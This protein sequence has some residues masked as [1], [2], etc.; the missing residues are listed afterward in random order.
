MPFINEDILAQ[1]PWQALERAVARL[2]LHGNFEEVKLVGQ[3]GD[4]GADVLAKR[5]GKRYLVQVKF[6]KH[7]NTSNDVVDEVLQSTRDYNAEVSIIATNRYFTKDVRK[8]Q[9][10][11]L[12]E[13]V[14][15][16]LW[17]YHKLKREWD[18]LEEFSKKMKSPREYQ[19]SPIKSI[20]TSYSSLAHNSGLVVMAT[21][22]GKTF[23]V[24]SAIGQLLSENKLRKV[25]VLAHTNELVYQLERSF[26]PYIS[27]N[28][29][30]NIY[31]GVEKGD[32]QN[33][34]I[35]FA[36][37]DT[38]INEL[39]INPDSFKS[40]DFIVIDEAHHAG[41]RTYRNIIGIINAGKSNGPYLL[42]L[43]ATPWRSDRIELTNIFTD[44]IC[45]ID[46]VKGMSEGYLTN[47][48]YRM[49]VDNI[50]WK[51]LNKLKNLTPKSLNKTLFIQEWDDA[52][53]DKLQDVWSEVNN[54]KAIV[55]CS[56]IEHAFT[57]RDR[58]NATGFA[59][60]SVLYSGAF[61]GKSINSYERNIILNNFADG[62]L[63]VLCAVDIL[64]EGIDVPDVN[65]IVFQRVTH[66]RR[67][68]VQQLGRGL[69]IYEGKEKVIVLDFV[70]DI[71][72]FAA[73][74]ELK[75][76][77][78]KTNKYIRLGS[79]IKFVDLSGENPKTENFLKEWLQDVAAIQDAGENDHV[80][81]F[82]PENIN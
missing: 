4:K 13:N 23:V 56:R 9:I 81:K 41:S 7:N 20:V 3:S 45:N 64:N 33:S 48:D 72:R 40:F 74:L 10:E 31:N 17:D 53:L 76:N 67:I 69:R 35:T 2:M 46:I 51:Q 77:L 44:K 82:P 63:N 36:C 37:S 29:T 14:S 34:I 60:A 65:I 15:L 79:P 49:H 80:L 25:L 6:R 12:K 24:A 30:T 68:F 50:D 59:R 5:F 47:V 57:F 58:I 75:E 11:L 43:T 28:I 39:Q 32:L 55:F 18:S 54:P 71:R 27:K 19:K 21:G 8:R 73:G 42:G 78:I 61:A 38:V 1:G 52:V 26:W 70:S 62:I 22:L 16:Q 66:S